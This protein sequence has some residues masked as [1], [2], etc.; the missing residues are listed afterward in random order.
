V[1][2]ILGGDAVR[3]Q[4]YDPGCA[5]C[6]MR[7]ADAPRR[8]LLLSAA[9]PFLPTEARQ[10]DPINAPSLPAVMLGRLRT[11]TTLRST[12]VQADAALIWVDPDHVSANIRGLGRPAG[13]NL[14]IKQG[15]RLRVYGRDTAQPRS[16]VVKEVA[17]RARL[18]LISPR[19][20]DWGGFYE[21]FDQ[22]LCETTQVRGG[23]SGAAVLDKDGRLAGIVVGSKADRAIVTP[24]ASILQYPGW[25]GL[26][27]W[28]DGAPADAPPTA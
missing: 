9:H 28:P 22:I 18:S 1:A 12:G 8:M 16:M 2:Q 4:T 25:A 24:I 20:N 17:G 26:E 23:D 3:Y 14:A 13:L 27:L 5:G 6:L 11:W 21:Y 15:D 7:F 19:P 10:N